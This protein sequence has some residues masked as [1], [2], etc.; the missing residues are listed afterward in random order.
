MLAFSATGWYG[1]VTDH[2]KKQLEHIENT[3]NKIIKDRQSRT[4]KDILRKEH[5]TWPIEYGRMRVYL[6]KVLPSGDRDNEFGN[7]L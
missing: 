2:L 7:Q 6:Y 1:N 5:V 3:T 4:L